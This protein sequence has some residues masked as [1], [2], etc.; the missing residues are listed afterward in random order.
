M[1]NPIL[2]VEEWIKS[3]EALRPAGVSDVKSQVKKTQT[4]STPNPP[5]AVTQPSTVSSQKDVPP[6]PV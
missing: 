3:A 1:A 4:Y 6:P 2:M 5:G